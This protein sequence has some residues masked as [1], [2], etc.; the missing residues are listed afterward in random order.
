MQGGRRRVLIATLLGAGVLVVGASS[1]PAAGH[2]ARGP[3]IYLVSYHETPGEQGPT[4]KLEA[5]SRRT[6][7]VRFITSFNREHA[8]A[9]GRY[10]SE[11][12]R[13]HGPGHPWLPHRLRGGAH[14][15]SLVRRALQNR[16]F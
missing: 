4:N 3:D 10:R 15:V 9:P 6:E 2:A 1:S 14:V 12:S 8:H 5:W 16:G 11:I 13:L 7:R